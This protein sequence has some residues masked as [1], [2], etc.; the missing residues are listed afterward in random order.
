MTGTP[1]ETSTFSCTMQTTTSN[2][3]A[4]TRTRALLSSM[5]TSLATLPLKRPRVLLRL[6]QLRSTPRSSSSVRTAPM[7]ALRSTTQ[8]LPLTPRSTLPRLALISKRPTV[9]SLSRLVRQRQPFRSRLSLMRR[10]MCVTSRLAFNFP[11]SLLLVPSFRRRTSRLSTLS[12][13]SSARRE[14]MPTPRCSRRSMTTRRSA[15]AASS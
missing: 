2:Y 5:T 14:K 12:P 10:A 3:L 4:R 9:L 8:Q 11:T 15:G 13:M 1:I 7:V 6:S